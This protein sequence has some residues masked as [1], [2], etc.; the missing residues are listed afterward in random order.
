MS[1]LTGVA[2]PGGARRI[3]MASWRPS[4]MVR[5]SLTWRAA[6][7]LATSLGFGLAWF[8][9]LVVGLALSAGLLV[10]WVGVPLLAAVMLI[11]RGGA[12]LERRLLRA[13]FGVTVPDPYRPMPPSS[14][15]LRRWRAMATDPATWKD[16][17]YLGLRFPIGIAEFV[18]SVAVWGMAGSFL[19]L[20]AIVVVKDRAVINFGD[21][22]FYTADDPL[23]ALPMSAVG[24][25]LL[26]V[27]MYV[28][29]GM[30][31]LHALYGVFLLGAGR[32]QAERVRLQARAEHLQ[33]SRA[34]GVDAAEAERRRI[35]RDLHDGAQQR[36][37][38]VAMDIGRA[39]AKLDDDPE[40]ARAL[41]EQAHAGTKEAIAELRDLA[42]GI[43]PAILTDRGL[44][45]AISGLA[46]RAPVPVLV[47]VDL[48]ERPP[49]AVE[50]IAYFIVAESL[51]NIAKY[52][53]ATRAS[54]RITRETHWVVVEVTDNG[55][56]GATSTP[57][58]GLAGLADRAAT[59]D[60]ILTVDSP[61]GGP[62]VIRA[63][64][65]CTW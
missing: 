38:A 4:A 3:V 52:A 49:A 48:P 53:R 47:E 30:A 5:S 34:R 36:L 64:L 12:M 10:I 56:G 46:A 55:V 20:P 15:L 39:R 2:A 32:D 59:I 7:Y 17:A 29:R 51:A 13:G 60:G 43:Y 26:L 6:V 61:P 65:P 58:G 54:V 8:V 27:A 44:D 37:L 21:W 14:G 19:F 25:V 57:G 28:T 33:A 16:L 41:I 23:T 24:V 18:V 50:S 42:R 11:W 1:E 31:V 9:F 45:P 35:E 63:D 40:G 22:L 62:T